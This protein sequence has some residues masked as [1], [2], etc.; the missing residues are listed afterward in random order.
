M[1]N[2]DR[3]PARN[4]LGEENLA[5]VRR[6]FLPGNVVFG[7]HYYYA[8]GCSGDMFC[9]GDFES[10]HRALERSRPGDHFTVY[11]ADRLTPLAITS[12]AAQEILAAG[13][14]IV[15][16]WR[17]SNPDTGRIE[18]NAETIEDYAELDS[19]RGGEYLF[20]LPEMLDE[21]ED[22]RPI[23]SVSPGTRKR[24]HAIA[25]GKRPDEDGLTPPSGPY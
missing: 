17:R 16:V 7:W 22:G 13:R 23:E 14:E 18:C 15:A 5:S 8:G 19:N 10:Y 2:W 25:D 21:D 9:F 20:F 6:E 24:I 1:S 11:S 3:T 12:A 4:L